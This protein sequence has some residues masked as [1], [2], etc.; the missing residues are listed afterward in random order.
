M[1]LYDKDGKESG[2]VTIRTKFVYVPPD[3]EINP[4][5]NRNCILKLCILSIE[6]FKDADT[7]GK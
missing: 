1:K 2:E 6:T 4:K 5:L 7:F 3:P